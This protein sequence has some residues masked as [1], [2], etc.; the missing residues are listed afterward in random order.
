MVLRRGGAGSARVRVRSS[1]SWFG[2]SGRRIVERAF[3]EGF[4]GRAGDP[5]ALSQGFFVLAADLGVGEPGVDERHGGALMA[6]DGHDRL[7]PGAAFGQLGAD[8]ER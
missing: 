2:A 1:G 5:V 6:E 7:D 4:G 8:G 3:K